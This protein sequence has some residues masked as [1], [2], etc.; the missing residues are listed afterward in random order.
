[1]K[2]ATIDDGA[3]HYRQP[4]NWRYAIYAGMLAATVFL[5]VSRG[6]P[7]ASGL[8]SPTIVGREVHPPVILDGNS[9]MSGLVVHLLVSLIYGIL[10]APVITRMR[11]FFA[12]LTGGALGLGLYALNAFIFAQFFPDVPGQRES[13]AVITH[14]AFGMVA[15]AAYK[16]MV[17]GCGDCV[18]DG[19]RHPQHS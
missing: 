1:M 6:I 12:V 16:G 8:M 14:M 10:M 15:A 7:W 9:S 5:F 4:I 11:P 13:I 18:Y 2:R 3:A 17:D 19:V